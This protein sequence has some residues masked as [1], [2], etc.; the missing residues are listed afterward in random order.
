MYKYNANMEPI[1]QLCC[2][3]FMQL[4][5]NLFGFYSRGAILGAGNFHV[6]MVILD[7]FE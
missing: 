7:G 2:N 5:N 4:L 6:A 3:V 1:C